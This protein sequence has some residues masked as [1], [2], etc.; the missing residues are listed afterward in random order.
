MLHKL[1]AAV[2]LA[3]SSA[4]RAD[5]AVPPAANFYPTIG[6][7][8]LPIDSAEA[9]CL[10]IA[11]RIGINVEGGVGAAQPSC[12]TAFYVKFVESAGARAAV[13]PYNANSTILDAL[14]ASLNGILFTG[15]GL[16]LTYNSTYMLT[17]E[18]DVL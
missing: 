16:D 17:G 14:F 13:I 6:I 3:T 15:G 5:T 7:L 8:S 10:S 9:P 4:L 1:V 12:M 18:G 2:S 11:K